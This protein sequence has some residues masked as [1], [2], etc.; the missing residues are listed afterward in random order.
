MPFAPAQLNT[1][2]DAIARG[3]MAAGQGIGEAM[4]LHKQNKDEAD[5]LDA[6]LPLVAQQAS[7][8]GYKPDEATA[9]ALAGFHD[10]NLSKKRGI[11]GQYTANIATYHQQ[12]KDE[13]A[14]ALQNAQLAHYNAL[15][16]AEQDRQAG[17]AQLGAYQ[18][19]IYD[20]T[21]PVLT[22]QII[23]DYYDKTSSETGGRPLEDFAKPT[24]TQGAALKYYG[25][26]YPQAAALAAPHVSTAL[27]EHLF[28]SQRGKDGMFTRSDLST[29]LPKGWARIPL[30]PNSS[31]AVPVV[32]AGTDGPNISTDGQYYH[33]GKNWRHIKDTS[34]PPGSKF[35]NINGAVALVG[36]DDRIRDWK[37][38]TPMAQVMQ[39]A[40][41]S[42]N[43]APTTV[44]AA[45]GK[46][47]EVIRMTKD[48][49]RA[50]FNADTKQFIRYAE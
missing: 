18:G 5:R 7:M 21:T 34:A 23:G 19:G 2:G 22:P 3:L 28:N 12:Q 17:M 16:Q 27:E 4:L 30:G 50:V 48:G 14:K 33:D 1:G 15:T 9:K 6:A 39:A 49:K 32:E 41:V 45:G 43:G 31:Q 46:A 25:E 47:N 13:Q 20:A 35:V 42:G 8:V 44:A 36:P 29:P 37:M 10:A 26:Q 24:M 40:G 38:A 11:I